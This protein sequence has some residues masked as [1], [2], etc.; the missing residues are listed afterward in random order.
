MSTGFAFNS[1]TKYKTITIECAQY[2]YIESELIYDILVRIGECS[3]KFQA[4]TYTII[5][6]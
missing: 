2:T 6:K 5:L 4:A 1:G 3:N